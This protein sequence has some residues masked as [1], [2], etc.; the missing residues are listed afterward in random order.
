MVHYRTGNSWNLIK[1]SII[2]FDIITSQSTTKK[3]SNCGNWKAFLCPT[4][5]ESNC[6]HSVTIFL[7]DKN[8]NFLELPG[9]R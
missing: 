6:A 9:I 8:F 4:G 7:F 2:R 1:F 5:D 3:P